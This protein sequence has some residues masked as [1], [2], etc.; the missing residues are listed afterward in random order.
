MKS[1][2][3]VLLALV[4]ASLT[5]ASPIVERSGPSGTLVYPTGSTDFL[6]SDG[7]KVQFNRVNGASGQYTEYID[8]TLINKSTGK[9]FVLATGITSVGKT[10]PITAYYRIPDGDSIPTS[11]STKYEL[12]VTEHQI[13]TLGVLS[14]QSAA[15]TFSI[16]GYP[17]GDSCAGPAYGDCGNTE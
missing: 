12:V 10:T 9:S 16:S 8:L 4:A 11:E 17:S 6:F 7:L 1:F 2:T 13:G 3:S 5:V 15:P 14:F